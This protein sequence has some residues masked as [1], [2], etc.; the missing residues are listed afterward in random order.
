MDVHPGCSEE[1]GV[2]QPRLRSDG[3]RVNTLENLRSF[4][5]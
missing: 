4:D 1:V 5:T 2:S 3:P